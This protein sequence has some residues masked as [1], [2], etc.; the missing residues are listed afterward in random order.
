[1]PPA[2][3]VP[4]VAVPV[5]VSVSVSVSVPVPVPVPVLRSS[6]K[7]RVPRSPFRSSFFLLRS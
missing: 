3:I 5:L 7:F 4:P 6:F 1:M 2:L